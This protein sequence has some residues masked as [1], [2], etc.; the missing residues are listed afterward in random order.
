M[1]LVLALIAEKKQQFRQTPFIKFLQDKSIDPMQRLAFAPYFAPFVMGFAELNKYVWRDETNSDPIQVIINEY[2][3]EDDHHWIWFLEDLQLLEFNSS[4]NLNDSLKFLWSDE[5]Q[6]SRQTI[7]EIYRY[8]AQASPIHKLVVI[9]AIEAIADIF[10][11]TTAQVTEELKLTTN[12]E[13]PYFGSYHIVTESNH[14]MYTSKT[15][16]II[17]NIHLD[18][19]TLKESLQLVN[20]VF[21]LFSILVDS[22]LIN[23]KKNHIKQPFNHPNGEA[24][25]Q[26]TGN[27]QIQHGQLLA[28]S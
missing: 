14:Q 6:I 18:T 15:A 17:T 26:L 22:L 5:T 2:T 25:Q 21:D 8:T 19:E 3:H 23:A 12:R 16:E 20:Q 24:L 9:E 7:H 13:Y 11:S 27:S 10:L 4:L 28:S 1:K